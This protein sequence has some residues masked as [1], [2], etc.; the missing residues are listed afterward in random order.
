MD[1][2]FDFVSVAIFV[3]I[4]GMFLHFSKYA[5]QKLFP[6]MAAAFGCAIANFFGNEGWPFVAWMLLLGVVVYIYQ[7]IYSQGGVAD[8]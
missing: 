1:T 6:Y 3:V 5:E 7:Q 2:I 4:V 8:E